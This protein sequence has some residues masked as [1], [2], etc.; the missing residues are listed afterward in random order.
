MQLLADQRQVDELDE[1]AYSSL[2]VSRRLCCSIAGRCTSRVT[3]VIA[4]S[5]G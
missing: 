4:S 3:V 1:R 5:S 2:P